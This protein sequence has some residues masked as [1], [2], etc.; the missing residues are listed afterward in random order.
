[1]RALIMMMLA[2]LGRM[3]NWED[4]KLGRKLVRMS[5]VFL[6]QIMAQIFGKSSISILT[7]PYKKWR[8]ILV[9]TQSLFPPD[10]HPQCSCSC[11]TSLTLPSKLT[12]AR[13][14]NTQ[15]PWSIC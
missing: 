12:L 5:T 4:E 9:Y 1:M 8:L 7:T 10:L 11:S 3:G 6:E 15:L 14:G 13:Q 2:T